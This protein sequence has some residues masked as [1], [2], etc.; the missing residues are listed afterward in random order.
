M[1]KRNAPKPKRDISGSPEIEDTLKSEIPKS[2]NTE[3]TLKRNAPKLTIA[4]VGLLGL[5]FVVFEISASRI[6]VSPATLS[7]SSAISNSISLAYDPVDSSLLKADRDGLQ[8][9]QAKTG[10]E[11]VNAPQTSNLSGVVI[12][13]DK[14]T[15][16]YISGIGM[17]VARSDDGGSN[18]KSVNANLP[19]LDVTALA[20]HSFQRETLF[21][22]V[23]DLGVYRTID[24]GATWL[25][26]RGQGPP[27]TNVSGLV[28][29]TLPGSMNTGWLYAD[30]PTGAYLSMDCF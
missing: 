13:P 6:V 1:K 9:W 17:G 10:W 24:S 14:P 29:S 4:V 16:L 26:M 8:R 19:S 30:T 2:A 7:S 20:L 18:W 27:D 28:H 11:T 23:K 25:L 5:L 12:N 22:W 3:G 21:A 15:T